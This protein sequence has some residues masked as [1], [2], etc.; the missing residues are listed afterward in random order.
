MNRT[1]SAIRRCGAGLA[2]LMLAAFFS[3]GAFAEPSPGALPNPAQE[4]RARALQKEFRCVVC[5]GESLDESRAPLA[6]DLRKLIRARIVAGESDEQI[7]Q[8]LVSRYG[9]FILMKPPLQP[10]TYVLWFGPALVLVVGAGVVVLVIGRARRRARQSPLWSED[11][12]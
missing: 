3:A 9:D 4:A 5:Q 6:A 11:H 2:I 1:P 12:Q 8:F 7:K 10:D